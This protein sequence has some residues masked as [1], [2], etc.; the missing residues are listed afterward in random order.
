MSPIE[1]P[2]RDRM[3]FLVGAMR[4]GTNWLQRVVGAHPDVALIPSETYL[5]SHGIKPLRER[6]HHGVRGSPGTGYIY[7][8]HKEMI[9]SLRELC[10]RVFL[11]FL[12]ATPGATRL[13]ERTPQ[14]VGCLDV[15]GE[16]Y[17]DAPVVHIVRDG[18]DVARSLLGQNYGPDTIEA[19]AAEWR[20]SVAAGES[21]GRN[22]P[23]YRT[24]RY[25][26]LLADPRGRV[27]ELYD[28]LELPR[29]PEIVEAALIEAEVRFNVDPRAP[30]IGVGK[31]RDEFSPADL[32]AFMK[33]AAPMLEALGYETATPATVKERP[34]RDDAGRGGRMLDPLRRFRGRRRAARV[35][36]KQMIEHQ[37]L[38]DR[39]VEAIVTRRLDRL[40]ELVGSPFRVRIV[41]VGEDWSGRGDLAWERLA[42]AVREDNAFEGRQTM[43]DLN[44]GVP[45]T[46]AVLTFADS[47]GVLHT[48][49]IVASF[50][51]GK[52]SR[53]T[54][55]RFPVAGGAGKG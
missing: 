3:I 50:R 36:D 52:L 13:A 7:M 47:D 39:V 23:R 19:A 34:T 12:E 33:V 29:T 22:L 31:W 6:F 43:G 9:R 27:V 25:E 14:H 5:F 8:D 46:T 38:G 32:A 35:G 42:A 49:T 11:P 10:D 53:L 51:D 16:I 21:A 18:R 45:T 44:P 30:T 37:R 41:G 26:E 40:R 28:W 17:P 15:I 24:I 55:Y 1:S 2:L 20:D 54:Y 4:S 48:R